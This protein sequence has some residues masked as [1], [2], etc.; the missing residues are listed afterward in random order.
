MRPTAC[1]RPPETLATG[2]GV[3]DKNSRL[4]IKVTGETRYYYMLIHRGAGDNG[5]FTLTQPA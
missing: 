2:G 4:D 5:S 3:Q 1:P